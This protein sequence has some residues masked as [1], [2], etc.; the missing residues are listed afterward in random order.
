MTY[1]SPFHFIQA[2]HAL[3]FD[4]DACNEGKCFRFAVMLKTLFPEGQIVMTVDEDHVAFKWNNKLYDATG[5]VD[6]KLWGPFRPMT[7]KEARSA[8]R[9]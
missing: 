7:P 4:A 8:M 5:K 2:L 9:W 6:R 3:P 1:Q